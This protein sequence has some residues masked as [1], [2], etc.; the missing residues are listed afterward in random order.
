MQALTELMSQFQPSV[1][2]PSSDMALTDYVVTDEV[3]FIL[4]DVALNSYLMDSSQ[5]SWG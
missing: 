3:S 1:A 2:L 5:S 4:L